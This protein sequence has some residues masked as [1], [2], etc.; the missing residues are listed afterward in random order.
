M[1]CK[2]GREDVAFGLAV[3]GVAHRHVIS[4]HG[5]GDG[6]GRAAHAEKPAHHFLTSADFGEGA[7]PARVE[8]DAQRFVMSIDVRFGH[9]RAQCALE[10]RRWRAWKCGDAR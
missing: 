7:I 6:A 1:D 5:F 3:N 10:P 4:G 9:R 8:V 2:R